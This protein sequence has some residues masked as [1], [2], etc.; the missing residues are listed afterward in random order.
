M[1]G[2]FD[3][4]L[5]EQPVRTITAATAAAGRVR[6]RI[7]E[8]LTGMAGNVFLGGYC[9]MGRDATRGCRPPAQPKRE[10]L[11]SGE[12]LHQLVRSG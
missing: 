2:M 8:G 12:A 1:A 6:R 3:M 10:R 9:G 5:D 11:L 7:L 4:S